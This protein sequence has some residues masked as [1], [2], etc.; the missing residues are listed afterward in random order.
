MQPDLW[1]LYER[2]LHS[3]LFEQAVAEIWQQGLIS[4]EMHLGLGEEAIAAGVVSHLIEGDA[5]AL[6]HRGTPPLLMRGID[7]G[8][9]LLEFLGHPDGLCAGQG[10]HMHLFAPEKLSASSGIVG[11]SGPGAAG[12]ALAAQYLRPGTVAIAFFGE[13]AMNQ[14]MLMESMNLAAAWKLPVL[15]VC[16]DNEWAITT[17]SPTVTGGSLPDR[18]KGFGLPVFEADG[19]EVES[20]W[21]A[22]HDALKKLRGGEGPAFIHTRCIHLEGH[23]LGDPL[24]RSARRPLREMLPLTG[25]MARA[26]LRRQGAPPGERVAGMLAIT[27]LVTGVA[28]SQTA[29]RDDP[30]VRARQKLAHDAGRLK[31]LEEAVSAEIQAIVDEALAAVR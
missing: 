27:R 31:A 7:P 6:D 30:L 25:P 11:A 5:L 20:V 23:F 19:R 10:G 24:L 9:L 28:R 16:K 12:F 14:G 21:A 13:G 26:A 22:A 18:A 2:M 29:R 17:G 1:P 3:R 8:K 4:G 15:F